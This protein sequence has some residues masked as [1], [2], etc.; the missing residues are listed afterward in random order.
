MKPFERIKKWPK[1]P[2][3][4]KFFKVLQKKEKIYFLIFF[5]SAFFSSVFLINSFYL[6]NTK[7][8]AASGG[9]YKEG[10]IGQPRFI[11]PIYANSDSDR[12][13]VQ[14]IFSGLMKYDKDMKIVPDLAEKYEISKNGKTYTF[15][16]RKNIFWQ[17]EQPIKADDVVFT[18]KTIQ[19]QE[20]K[21]PLLPNWVGVKVEKIDDR[22]IKFNLEK[23]Y[24]AFL[25]NCTL[26]IL[27]MHIW[28]KV[29]PK[30]L[31]L[32]NDYNLNPI[33]SGPFKIKEMNRTDS[34]YIKSAT[35]IKNPLYFGKNPNIAKIEFLFFNN[36]KE[37][38]REAKKGN[39]DGLFLNSFEE[40]GN[41][42]QT[43]FL[44]FPR[45][46]S[47]FFNKNQAKIFA[48]KN[49]RLALNYAVDRK[50]IVERVF[51]TKENSPR[52]AREIS[53]S[54]ILPNIYGFKEPKEIYEFNPQKAKE[55][56]EKTGF[57]ENKNGLR[58]KFVKEKRSFTFEKRLENGSK[59]KDVEE[60]QKCLAS[61]NTDKEKIYPEGKIT[62]Y[63]GEKTK[64]AVINLQEKYSKEIL[65]PWNFKQGTG[66]VGKTTQKK[67]NE[68]CFPA[69]EETIPLKFSLVT[70]DQPQMLK[71]AEILKKQWGAIGV[72][73]EIKKLPLSQLEQDFIRPRK[74]EAL[75]LGEVLGAIPDPLPFW[76]SSQ[77]IDP[78][79][80]LSL[81]ENKKADK[82]LE[83]NR[84]SSD[85][86]T[87]EE[88][89]ELFQNIVIKDAPA[90]FLYSPDYIYVV[91]KKIKGIEIKKISEPSKRFSEIENWYLKTK[92]VW[93]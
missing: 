25:E 68:I 44:S 21:S 5:I 33:G 84:E 14:L 38:I 27:P 40:L 85:P 28:E 35:L 59:G 78:G 79:L 86:K 46:F 22:T 10:V 36:E 51:G 88:K 16:L 43:Y 77:K 81:Y 23:P 73:V 6:K 82:L 52:L 26:K 29:A 11:N 12:D 57:K 47:V 56:L 41:N 39:I 30:N 32:E 90:V 75:L 91:S 50:E 8:E 24:S 4:K 67:L 13:L 3:W 2:Q 49:V 42:W 93:K 15:Y 89:L 34:N 9:T 71:V 69:S 20:S 55:I 45:Y 48:D 61:L 62:G 7:I 54:P 65:E 58:E 63:F 17:D 18:V 70:V 64:Q 87:R 76:H 37:L 83:E 31:P 66:I 1:W 19:N 60:L 92:R 74:Y 72:E 53:Q 80:N